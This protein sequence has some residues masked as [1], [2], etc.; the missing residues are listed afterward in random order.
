MQLKKGS[1]KLPFYFIE[2]FRPKPSQPLVSIAVNNIALYP[3][4]KDQK[5]S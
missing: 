4:T 1:Y 3:W 2:N 5:H